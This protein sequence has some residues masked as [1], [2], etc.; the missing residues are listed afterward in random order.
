MSDQAEWTIVPT[1]L[2]GCSIDIIK[3]VL[4]IESEPEYRDVVLDYPLVE[5]HIWSS[6]ENKLGKIWTVQPRKRPVLESIQFE[7]G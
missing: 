1:V 5:D 7:R 3:C 4:S 6:G 2:S